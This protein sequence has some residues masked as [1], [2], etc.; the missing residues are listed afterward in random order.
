MFFFFFYCQ[1]RVGRLF[2]FQLNKVVK[3]DTKKTEYTQN[4]K[5]QTGILSTWSHDWLYVKKYAYSY[6]AGSVGTGDKVG[7]KLNIFKF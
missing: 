7:Q 3:F 4:E 1:T 6:L 2:E 5:H